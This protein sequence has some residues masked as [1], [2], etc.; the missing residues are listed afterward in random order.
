MKAIVCTHNSNNYTNYDWKKGNIS[1]AC[2]YFG[3][4]PLFIAF[5]IIII[6]LLT[7]YGRFLSK[8][9]PDWLID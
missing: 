1:Y 3:F 9:K 5:I 7:H 2:F 8:I 4:L 6:Y